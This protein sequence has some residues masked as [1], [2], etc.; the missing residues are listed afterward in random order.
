MDY[1]IQKL[2]RDYRTSGDPETGYKLNRFLVLSGSIQLPQ[3]TEE[4][5]RLAL[6][7]GVAVIPILE[8]IIER[9]L[10]NTLEVD[11][12]YGVYQQAI[13]SLGNI[14]RGYEYGSKGMGPPRFGTGYTGSREYLVAPGS[15][16]GLPILLR[17][18]Q[19]PETGCHDDVIK[20]I[21]LIGSSTAVPY[22]CDYVDQFL[23]NP[24]RRRA[25]KD[26]V[27][28]LAFFRDSRAI[29]TLIR[30]LDHHTIRDTAAEALGYI[31]PTTLAARHALEQR[32][33][34]MLGG[35]SKSAA[36]ALGRVGDTGAIP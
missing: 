27:S 36:W 35:R 25:A 34:G 16:H 5:Y 1:R 33:T 10:A 24:E 20:A 12:L 2:Q 18:L 4:V 9:Y 28:A 11:R 31:E 23:E 22:L 8:E 13:R 19:M 15:I 29:P 32:T 17:I 30:A 26:A 3:T 14:A 6:N 7:E 21:R